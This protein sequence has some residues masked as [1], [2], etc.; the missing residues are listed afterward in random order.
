MVPH[1]ES[2]ADIFSSEAALRVTSP[3][4]LHVLFPPATEQCAVCGSGIEGLSADLAVCLCCQ[5]NYHSQCLETDSETF[6]PSCPHCQTLL[7][8]SSG[9]DFVEENYTHA[10]FLEDNDTI[11]QIF[12]YVSRNRSTN[13]QGLVTTTDGSRTSSRLRELRRLR[14]FNETVSRIGE[15]LFDGLTSHPDD[16]VLESHIMREAERES[17]REARTQRRRNATAAATTT[18]DGVNSNN[19]TRSELGTTGLVAAAAAGHSF[20]LSQ[21]RRPRLTNLL[22]NSLTSPPPPV[23]PQMSPEEIEAWNLLDVAESTDTSNS[24]A[25]ASSSSQASS[26][27]PARQSSI[28][29]PDRN[30]A[31]SSSNAL[32]RTV[33]STS[34][35]S[36]PTT[37]STTASTTSVVA[38]GSGSSEPERKFKRPNSSLSNGSYRSLPLH[39]HRDDSAPVEPTVSGYPFTSSSSSSTAGEP[40]TMQR[41][42]SSIRSSS[43]TGSPSAASSSRPASSAL[44]PPIASSTPST[45]L[46]STIQP[47][48]ASPSLPSSPSQ[49]ISPESRPTLP[50]TLPPPPPLSL[51]TDPTPV[52]ASVAREYH[53]P[54]EDKQRIKRI[55]RE[56]ITKFYKSK[57]LDKQQCLALE[58]QI[59]KRM[60][61]RVHKEH[62]RAIASPSSSSNNDSSSRTRAGSDDAATT[63]VDRDLTKRKKLKHWKELVQFYVDQKRRELNAVT[64][65]NSSEGPAAGAATTPTPASV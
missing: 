53:I 58:P 64:E 57:H 10:D 59:I 15:S 56:V 45:S 3:L 46:F 34:L 50:S 47:S 23:R 33:S 2:D 18:R 60:Y 21:T 54:P 30:S 27:V 16:E 48:S 14:E 20:N 43:T 61:R 12:Q 19:S 65:P 25:A 13:Q 42:L 22:V 35:D 1:P 17:R 11:S 40:T 6:Y 7:V 32:K 38:S 4:M 31:S 44:T 5:R 63:L 37:A 39:Q 26:S 52:S 55:V 51:T 9:S 36:I 24:N 62:A 28:F 29:H 8:T 41:L 49:A